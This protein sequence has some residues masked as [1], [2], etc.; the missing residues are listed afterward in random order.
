[1]K[2]HA[3]AHTDLAEILRHASPDT[4]A[5]NADRII[6][7]DAVSAMN[8]IVSGT[9][10]EHDEQSALIAWAAMNE[11]AHPELAQLF[12]IPNGGKRHIITAVRLKEEGLKSGVPDLML[13]VAR[14]KYHGLFIEM[15]R[16]QGR[17]SHEQTDW[18]ARL[19]NFGYSA[20][21]CYGCDE[22]INA[23][24]AYLAQEG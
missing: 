13:A 4:A 7:L 18:I 1:V 2:R 20:L 11:V 17:R 9:A 6:G 5:L 14:G 12:S 24:M 10:T 3:N 8:A 19:R 16:K 15:K 23:I 22:A 21:T